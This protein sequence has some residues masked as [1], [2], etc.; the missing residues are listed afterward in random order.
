MTLSRGLETVEYWGF[1]FR[2]LGLGFRVYGSGFRTLSR[3][4]ETVEYSVCQGIPRELRK[5][6]EFIPV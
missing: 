1:G 3:G 2:V 6:S 5:Q 4:L